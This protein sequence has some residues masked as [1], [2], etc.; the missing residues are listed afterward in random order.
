MD[1][2]PVVDEVDGQEDGAEDVKAAQEFF[3]ITR[4]VEDNGVFRR[5]S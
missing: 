5:Q 2:V 1:D 3:E 4:L